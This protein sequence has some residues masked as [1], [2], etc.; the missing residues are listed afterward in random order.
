MVSC[1][2]DHTNVLPGDISGDFPS[3]ACLLGN[4]LE[5]AGVAI[6][7]HGSVAWVSDFL[8]RYGLS[9]C[10]T[11]QSAIDV[12]SFVMLS[13]AIKY[14]HWVIAESFTSILYVNSLYAFLS[15]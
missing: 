11:L 1:V 8:S 6:T 5:A 10:L 4:L 7:Q 13:A 14:L 15:S 9:L 2:K 12:S 3:Y